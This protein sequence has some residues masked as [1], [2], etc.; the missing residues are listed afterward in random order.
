V[1][2]VKL[3]LHPSELAPGLMLGHEVQL[4]REIEIGGG[5]V[6]HSGT[7][8]GDRCELQDCAVLGK[9]ARHGKRSTTHR[10]VQEPLTVEDDAVICAGAVIYAGARIGRGA[11]VGDQAQVR[12][13]SSIGP[14]SVIGRG[15]GIESGVMIGAD[16]RIQSNCYFPSGTVIEDDVFVGPAVVAANDNTMG[17]HGPGEGSDAPTLRRAC[18]IGIGAVIC[19]GVEIG[20]EAFI[21]AGALVRAD[22]PPRAVMMG[23][24]ATQRR[25]VGDEDLAERWT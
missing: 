7:V 9:R 24:P 16:V 3:C 1:A 13:H 12:E 15:S 14:G 17:R 2:Q 18:R 11:I 10:E 6:I 5:V 8:V 4:G 23:V 25:E 19:P 22:V 21:A 20:E